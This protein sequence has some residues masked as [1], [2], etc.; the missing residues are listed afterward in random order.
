MEKFFVNPFS[1]SLFGFD[2]SQADYRREKRQKER[3][4]ERI[5]EETIKRKNN[6]PN[7]LELLEEKLMS[8]QPSML[9]SPSIVKESL[10]SSPIKSYRGR[11]NV[12]ED[13]KLF[14]KIKKKGKKNYV[15]TKAQLSEGSDEEYW[16]AFFVRIQ[17]MQIAIYHY[18]FF[19]H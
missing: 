4:K 16:E 12:A 15:E 11:K 13:S 17:S 10:T 18:F 7:E 5:R 6:L 2:K 1:P 14:E 9:N 8:K 19:L 3:E